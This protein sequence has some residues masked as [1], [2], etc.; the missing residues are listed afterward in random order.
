MEINVL[1]ASSRLELN[2]LLERIAKLKEVQI[3]DAESTMPELIKF[4]FWH[5]KKSFEEGRNIS[6]KFEIEVLIRA[7]GCRQIKEAINKVGVKD[8]KKILI[9][10]LGP[11]ERK[12]KILEE[13]EAEEQKERGVLRKCEDE[14]EKKILEIVEL[15]LSD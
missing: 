12:E 3:F 2:E 11:K 5:A 7:S 15:E 10:F 14:F 1:S 13:L 9:G 4:A 8:P 6:K